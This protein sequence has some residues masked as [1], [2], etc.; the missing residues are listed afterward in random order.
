MKT[1]LKDKLTEK[2]QHGF[3]IIE[4]VLV[5]AIA[6]LIFLIVFLALPQ[7][8]R[9]QRDTQRQSDVGR[10]LSSME[11]YAA[12]NNGQYPPED[13]TF[14][15]GQFSNNYFGNDQFE[16]PLTGDRYEFS[17]ATPPANLSTDDHAGIMYYSEGSVCGSEGEFDAAQGR[18]IAVLTA[19]ENGIA[20]CQDNR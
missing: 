20:Y 16:D 6:G 17:V 12:N 10:T 18:N 1:T 14:L 3:T 13:A 11:T 2:N 8:Q 9:S 15:N 5:L 19:V 7:L 4:V